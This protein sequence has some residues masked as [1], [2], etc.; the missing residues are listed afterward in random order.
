MEKKEIEYLKSLDFTKLVC[1]ERNFYPDGTYYP[2]VL[3]GFY[4]DET[5]AEAIIKEIDP[6]LYIVGD[7]N[8]GIEI[9]RHSYWIK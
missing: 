1:K 4:P 9:S 2:T 5:E 7:S 3:Q 8:G 6:D